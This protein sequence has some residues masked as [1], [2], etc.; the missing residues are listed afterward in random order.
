LIF[1]E[2]VWAL[3][4]E[5]PRGRVTTYSEIA[6]KLGSKAFRAVGNACNRNPY[7]PVAACHRVV[8]SDGRVGGFASGPMRKISLL[9]N[10]GIVVD[11]GMVKDFKK[12][13][14]RF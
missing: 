2:K 10:E 3:L 8:R 1:Q 5:I 13:L 11:K 4:R 9:R 14:Y 12:R 6:R 7:A